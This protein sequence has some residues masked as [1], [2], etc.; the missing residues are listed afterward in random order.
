V[1]PTLKLGNVDASAMPADKR[2][3][4]LPYH[5][6]TGHAGRLRGEP[7]NVWRPLTPGAGAHVATLQQQLQ[8]VGLNPKGAIDG[9]FGYR[10]QSAVRLFQEYV[11]TI[12]SDPAIGTAD[13]IAGKKTHACIQQWIDN[14]KTADWTPADKLQSQIFAGLNQLRDHFLANPT[15]P[16]TAVLNSFNSPTCTRKV[17]DWKFDPNDTHLIGIRR[18]DTSLSLVGDKF[19]RRNDDIFVLLVNGMRIVFRGSTD[20]SPSMANREDAAFLIRGQHEYR[21]GW[22]KLNSIGTD[23]ENVYR[24]FKPK[25]DSGVLV[26]RARNGQLTPAS[27]TGGAQANV[28]INIHWSGSGTS[29]WSAGCQ[30]IAGKKYKN[31]RN[32]IVDLSDSASPGYAALGAKTRGAYNVLIDLAT[33]FADDIR[34][35]SSDT[36]YYTLLLESDLSAVPG[37]AGIDFKALV[38]EL[39]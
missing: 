9:I 33:V 32:D 2:Q 35:D 3:A 5:D 10:T 14:S 25:S 27:Y 20:P 18:D 8:T 7:N 6:W 23:T 26:V 24:A 19:V 39:S 15:D 37:S 30:V 1:P 22:H 13:G 12:D 16:A 17:V 29:N 38:A 36:L 4:T 28:T 21:F 31:I 34:C 11:R